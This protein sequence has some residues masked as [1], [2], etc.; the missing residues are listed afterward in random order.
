[1][2]TFSWKRDAYSLLHLC[3]FLLGVD[4]VK[5]DVEH[6]GEDEGQEEGEASEVSIP[7]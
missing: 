7:L 4:E 3:V 1:M 2:T 6:S 5:H